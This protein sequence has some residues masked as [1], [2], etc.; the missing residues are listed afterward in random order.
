MNFCKAGQECACAFAEYLGER[1]SIVDEVARELEEKGRFD[2]VLAELLEKWPPHDPIPLSPPARARVLQVKQLNLKYDQYE[3]KDAG[4]HATVYYA[5][6]VLDAEGFAYELLMDDAGGKRISSEDFVYISTQK[7]VLEMVVAGALSEEL[8]REV[9]EKS[10][11][12]EKAQRA[13]SSRLADAGF[14][15]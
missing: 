11:S 7:L 12:D 13:Y 1:V 3:N 14:N 15:P 9:W 8:G 4:E 5:E 6:E 2:P 10:L